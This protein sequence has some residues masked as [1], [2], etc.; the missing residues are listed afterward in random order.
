MKKKSDKIIL[1]FQNFESVITIIIAVVISLVIILSTVRVFMELYNIL[2]SDISSPQLIAFKEYQSL[3]GKIMTLLIS[4]EFLN[5]VLKSLKLHQVKILVLDVSLI[6]A[7]AIARKLIIYDYSKSD[8]TS[9]LIL[10]GLLVS[11][12]IFYF[13]VKFDRKNKEN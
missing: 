6:T 12:G 7:L 11:I 9:S 2:L 1:F 8:L 4:I 5:S 3:F 13:L 10:G